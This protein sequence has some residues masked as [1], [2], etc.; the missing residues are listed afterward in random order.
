MEALGADQIRKHVR[1]YLTVFAA[2]AVLT[3]GTVLAS[4]LDVSTPI[5]VVIA[6]IIASIKATLVASYFMHLISENKAIY[7]I[8]ILSVLFLIMVLL[9]PTFTGTEM[10]VSDLVSYNLP[11]RLCNPLDSAIGR[12]RP[13]GGPPVQG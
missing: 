4:Y 12:L 13:V 3:V 9:V 1:I 8:L 10:L 2:L 5:A 7:G 6:L 11:Y